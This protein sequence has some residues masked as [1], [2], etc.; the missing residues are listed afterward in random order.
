VNELEMKM[1]KFTPPNL[2]ALDHP[3]PDNNS[4]MELWEPPFERWMKLADDL[5][6]GWVSVNA[7]VTRT[8]KARPRFAAREN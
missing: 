4:E 1:N 8:R 6:T 7:S 3:V 2:H 5:L